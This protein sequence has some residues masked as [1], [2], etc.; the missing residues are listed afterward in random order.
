MPSAEGLNERIIKALSRS[1]APS[2]DAEVAEKAETQLAN[3]AE[4]ESI[5]FAI[6][7]RDGIANDVAIQIF[8][9]V[10]DVWIGMYRLEMCDTWTAKVTEAIASIPE[11]KEKYA[12]R[13][14]QCLAFTR[15][16][17]GRLR[18]ALD[19]FHQME[20]VEVESTALWE[21]IAH[22]YSS[23]GE[24]DKAKE[25]FQKCLSAPDL[26]NRGGVQLGL[27]ILKDRTGDTR[28]GLADCL[29]ALAW[30]ESRFSAAGNPSS[31]EAKCCMSIAKMYSSLTEYTDALTYIQ[32]AVSVFTSTC[33]SYSPLTASALKAHGDIL[34][35]SGSDRVTA[36]RLWLRALH[37]ET[38]KDTPDLMPMIQ[39]SQSIMDQV[40]N[41]NREFGPLMKEI[42]SACKSVK[43]RTVQDANAGAFY[44][45]MAEV[46][47]HAR[48]L[49]K[50]D[51]LLR[52]AI[53]LFK[54]SS[55]SDCTSLA[56]QSEQL[57]ALIAT[58]QK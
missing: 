55:S 20:A 16:K 50:A 40:N 38:T 26:S 41:S 53:P 48:E 2:G 8:L 3:E 1:Y 44:K 54:S 14:T 27:G 57:L 35:A 37:V 47:I 31:L 24:F 15:W 4:L 46:A 13:L 39:L 43:A 52:W 42:W 12:F 29:G 58:C 5:F 22:T 23:L 17:Q 6:E 32:R 10:F 30:Y 51:T 25:Y 34:S 45:I 56:A 33:G 7:Q 19:L 9:K 36:E 28:G 49:D 11:L 18:D 21:N